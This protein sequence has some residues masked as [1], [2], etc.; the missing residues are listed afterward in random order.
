MNKVNTKVRHVAYCLALGIN[1]LVDKG[2]TEKIETI[3]DKMD[4]EELLKYLISKYKNEVIHEFD[5]TPLMEKHIPEVDKLIGQ[6]S[7]DISSHS[8]NYYLISDKGLV[9]LNS[10]LLNILYN[11]I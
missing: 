5:F 3:I 8:D 9:L 6:Y 11:E 7:S 1:Q 2:Y 10:V 4:N